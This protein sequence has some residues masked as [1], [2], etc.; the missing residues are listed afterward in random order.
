MEQAAW[1]VGSPEV[2][3]GHLMVQKQTWARSGAEDSTGLLVG[4]LWLPDR[5]GVKQNNRTAW[6][7]KKSIFHLGT[8]IITKWWSLHIFHLF[9]SFCRLLFEYFDMQNLTV[10]TRHWGWFLDSLVKNQLLMSSAFCN[11]SC[12]EIFL[13][14]VVHVNLKFFFLVIVNKLWKHEKEKNKL[15]H[16]TKGDRTRDV[17]QANQ[18]TFQEQ[19]HA[20]GRE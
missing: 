5:L 12:K 11:S 20:T 4:S 1:Q 13:P 17:L 9:P 15:S 2:S 10:F 3:G 6:F 19:I 16:M 8:V 7:F 14:Q 18:S